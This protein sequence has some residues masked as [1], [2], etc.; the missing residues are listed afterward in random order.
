[1]LRAKELIVNKHKHPAS[2]M[3]LFS[4]HTRFPV[5]RASTAVNWR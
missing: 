2:P 4:S 3:T 1:M 5:Y